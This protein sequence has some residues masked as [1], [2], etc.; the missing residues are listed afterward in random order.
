MVCVLG[1]ALD[2][3]NL[4]VTGDGGNGSI[5]GA[6]ICQAGGKAVAEAVEGQAGADLSL[7]F[8]GANQPEE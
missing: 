5:V 3:G 4:F 7:R 1:V 2:H 8:Q 6:G